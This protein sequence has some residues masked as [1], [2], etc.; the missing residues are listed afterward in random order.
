MGQIVPI[1]EVAAASDGGALVR[2]SELDPR[3][4]AGLEGFGHV[5]VLW[6]AHEVDGDRW[7]PTVRNPYRGGPA[8]VGV[9]ATRAPGRPNPICLSVAGVLA[10]DPRE[11]VLHLAHLDARP[12]SPV[13]DIKPY[14]PS[15]DRVARTSVPAWCAGWPDDLE[16]SGAFDWSTVL[17]D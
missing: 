2:L 1:G 15:L 11:G 17:A 3:A 5:Q 12:G 6:W 8:T 14:T 10:V 16:S 9:L 4:L 7:E 13:L